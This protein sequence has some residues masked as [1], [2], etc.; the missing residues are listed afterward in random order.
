M[1]TD[2]GGEFKG[3]SNTWLKKNG[4]SHVTTVP[5][6]HSQM[7]MVENINRILGE[8]LFDSKG[9]QDRKGGTRL[10]RTSARTHCAIIQQET[11]ERRQS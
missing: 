4:N 2:G 6:R 9:V 3:S 7:Q 11:Q 5:S 8:E 10:D 1:Q